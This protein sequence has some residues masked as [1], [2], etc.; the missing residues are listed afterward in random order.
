MPDIL[1]AHGSGGKLTADL[2]R[3]HLLPPLAN[4]Y[5]DPLSDAA[6][7]E[8]IPEGRI[9]MTTDAFVVDPIVFPGGDLGYLSVCGCV[10]DLAVTGAQP[11]W[12]TWALILEEG[13]PGDLLDTI[14]RGAA[15]A[16]RE[17]GVLVVA[18]DTKVV[19]RGKAD[20][21]FVAASGVGVVPPGRHVSDERIRPGDVVVASG[22]LGDHGAT[23]MA[24]Q[25]DVDP[26]TLTSDCRPVS[27]LVEALF[28]TGEEIHALHDPTRGGVATVCHEVAR[29][30]GHEIRLREE[31]IPVREETWSVCHLLG[32]DPLYLACEGRVLVWTPES[33]ADRILSAIRSLDP[34]G[35]PAVI[36]RVTET[37]ATEAPLLL[38]TRAGGLRPLDMLSG[39][40]LPRIC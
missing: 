32:L 19:P 3:N 39:H 1:L 7:M 26:G 27:A 21:V 17:A 29:R 22:T 2:I 11:R 23:I 37:P 14:V 25:H 28:E 35:H 16:A 20:R 38:E 15:A 13:L 40:A 8:G 24:L 34:E 36:G 30:C 31:A 18:G 9:A 12:I 6:V 33:G 10:N 5:L 4:R